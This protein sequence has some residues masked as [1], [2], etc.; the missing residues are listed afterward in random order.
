MADA[1]TDRDLMLNFESIG[2]NCE[3]GLVQRQAGAEP[4]GLLRFSGA[5]LQH[6]ILALQ[7]R[8][9]GIAE[10]ENVRPRIENGE[11]MVKLTEYDFIYHAFVLEHQMDLATLH[12]RE[13]RRT[14]FL[15]RKLIAD[16]ETPEKLLVFRQNEPLDPHELAQLRA[17]LDG[18]ATHT[19]LWVVE[20]QPD[21]PPGTVEVVD[22]HLLRGYVRW[23]APRSNAT[24]IDHASWLSVCRTAHALWRS[25]D[26]ARTSL[27]TAARAVEQ[28]RPSWVMALFGR[29]GNGPEN[30]GFGWS[31]PEN[32]FT[33]A[34][35]DSSLLVLDAPSEAAHYRLEF[36]IAA[37][38][39][40]PAVDGP[41][42]SV[43][44]NGTPAH[45]FYRLASGRSSCALPRHLLH[46]HDKVEILLEYPDLARPG[47]VSGAMDDGRLAI[48][49]RSLTLQEVPG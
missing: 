27:S 49:F 2:D 16:L 47:D 4:L 15:T 9:S 33:W 42:L 41:H 40:P 39:A 44:V 45:Q 38:R 19:M 3:F 30:T 20:A 17:A 34:F 21:H 6:L 43:S 31:D 37:F 24:K 14:A 29:D 8:F 25:A 48:A 12:P 26:T 22:E 5:P 18:Y 10:P 36:D 11:Y 35:G 46:G 28:I 7:Q 13:V 32:G 23:L 1:L